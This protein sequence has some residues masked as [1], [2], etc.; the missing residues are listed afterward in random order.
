MKLFKNFR[1]VPPTFTSNELS[2]C[3]V[4]TFGPN[5]VVFTEIL[6]LLNLVNSNTTSEI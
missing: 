3:D 2:T 4:H 1:Q 5:G 6:Y